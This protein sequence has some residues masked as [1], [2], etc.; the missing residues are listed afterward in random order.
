MRL[1]I[2]KRPLVFMFPSI[3]L[4]SF[5]LLSLSGCGHGKPQKYMGTNQEQAEKWEAVKTGIA[6]PASKYCVDQ[7]F[8]WSSRKDVKGNEYG[9]C[10]FHDGS[11]CE[12]WAYYRGYCK[13]GTNITVCG[14]QFV[15]K[16]TCPGDYIPVCAKINSTINSSVSGGFVEKDFNNACFACTSGEPIIGYVFGTCEKKLVGAK[17]R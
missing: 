6:N 15:G 12:E 1:S 17:K 14:D 13:P 2:R 8:S 11:W 7:G 9:I 10:T 16:L 5:L 4:L 3:V